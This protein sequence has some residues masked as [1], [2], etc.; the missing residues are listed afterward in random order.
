MNDFINEIDSNFFL[1]GKKS[2]NNTSW[3]S[4]NITAYNAVRNSVLISELSHYGMVKIAGEDSWRV[5]NY[6]ISA[7]ISLIR[8]EQLLYTLLLD[9]N[10][11]IV[12]DAY[13][14]CENE[15]YYLITEWL[16]GN[17]LCDFINNIILKSSDFIDCFHIETIQSM[18]DR[19]KM[20]CVEGP[21]AWEVLSEIIGMD[22]IGLPFHEFMSIDNDL[23]LMRVGK[24]GEYCYYLIGTEEK[25]ENAWNDISRLNKKYNIAIGDVN[26]LKDIRLENPVWDKGLF[27][28]FS[29]CPVELQLQWAI[30]YDKDNFLG[31]EKI[32]ERSDN[33]VNKKFIG[34]EIVENENLNI[35]SGDFVFYK[36]KKIGIVIESG[37]SL[38]LDKYIVKLLLDTK[39]AYVGVNNYFIKTNN[40]DVNIKT[41]SMPFI[42]NVSLAVNPTEHSYLQKNIE[43]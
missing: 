34:A 10:G 27:D 29:K 15:S 39:Y 26:Y 41:K 33:G 8:D 2:V 23:F 31:K 32:S 35:T 24:H 17:E 16:T 7:D 18:N 36:N 13:V 30:N 12:L 43:I 37:K 20:I 4:G 22:V 11:D 1:T 3:F 38:F 28:N 9:S 25:L 5:L 6:I 14:V 42:N 21:Y 40:G 19:W